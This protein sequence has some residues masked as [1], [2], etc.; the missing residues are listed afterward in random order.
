A[1]LVQGLNIPAIRE[2]LRVE[3]PQS[4]EEELDQKMLA[5]LGQI[6]DFMNKQPNPGIMQ[7][8]KY[9]AAQMLALQQFQV[10]S[11]QQMRAQR[12]KQ[13][14]MQQDLSFRTAAL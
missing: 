3:N 12:E 11:K 8:Q 14:E 13:C 5:I 10:Q 6:Y 1:P 9:T 7:Q 4:T 2:A